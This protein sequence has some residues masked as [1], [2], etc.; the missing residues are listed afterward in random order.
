[1][2]GVTVDGNDAVADVRAAQDAIDRA[3]SGEGPTLLEAMTFRFLGHVSATRAS[4][5]RRPR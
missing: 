4:T 5:C 1:M 2:A 3:R